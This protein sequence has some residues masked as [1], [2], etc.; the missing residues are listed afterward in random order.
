MNAMKWVLAAA[1]AASAQ[2]AAYDTSILKDGNTWT[3][4]RHKSSNQAIEDSF[5]GITRFTIDSLSV[6]ADT[7]AFRVLRKDSLFYNPNP[8]GQPNPQI[9]FDTT[10]YAYR[11]GTFFPAVPFF[12]A[13][14]IFSASSARVVYQGDTLRMNQDTGNGCLRWN[15]TSVET[16]GRTLHSSGNGGCGNTLRSDSYT[17]TVFNGV[18]YNASMLSPVSLS[19][20]LARRLPDGAARILLQRGSVMF[21]REGKAFD[22][23]GQRAPARSV[24]LPRNSEEESR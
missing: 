2:T 22:L 9:T 19:A 15:Y 7:L 24:P 20:S 11:A 8:V 4:K 6:S 23:R 17:L 3:Y 10:R 13:G 1:L 5:N 12:A 21:D 14:T 18:A 16:I